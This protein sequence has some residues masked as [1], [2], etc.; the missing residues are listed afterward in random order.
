MKIQNQQRKIKRAVTDSEEP[1]RVRY[2]IENKPGVSNLLD[3]LSGVTGKK[4]AEL[5]AEF[6]GQMYGHLKGAVA[7]AVSGMLATL[8]ERYHQFRND[9]ALLNKI[10]DEGATKAAAR[11]QETVDKVYEAIG[12]VKRPQL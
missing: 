8:Q 7:D 5:E 9:E 3:I 6:E 4:I 2:D 10:M 1:P 12:F 11:A